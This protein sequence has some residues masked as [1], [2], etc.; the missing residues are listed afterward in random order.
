MFSVFIQF[1]LSLLQL[2]PATQPTQWTTPTTADTSP[3]SSPTAAVTPRPTTKPTT[4]S[5]PTNTAISTIISTSTTISTNTTTSSP[6]TLKLYR[7]Y[8][9]RRQ[10]TKNLRRPRSGPS[11]ASS[12]Q[13]PICCQNR[14]RQASDLE[15][16]T[17]R[18]FEF[19]TLFYL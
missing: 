6:H 3:T 7:T 5:T 18:I 10:S 11:S 17:C 13:P 12:R 2:Q 9:H 4:T 1:C 19:R 14:N 16:C 15:R 8:S